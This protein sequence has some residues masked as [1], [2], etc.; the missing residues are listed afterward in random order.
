MVWK[1]AICARTVS[2]QANGIKAMAVSGLQF[3]PDS[4][5]F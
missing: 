3:L 1:G 5:E 2:A 4:A